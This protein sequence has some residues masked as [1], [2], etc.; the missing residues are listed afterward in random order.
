[1]KPAVNKLGFTNWSY[2]LVYVDNCLAVH[3]DPGPVME[4]LK[5]RYKLKNDKY[6]EPDRYLGANVGKY[7]LAH[8]GGKSYWSMHAYDY[9]V[10]SC[11]MVRIWSNEDERKWNNKRPDA[12]KSNYRPEI[13]F[14]DELGDNLATRFQQMT[15]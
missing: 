13:D 8:N 9:V 4:K 6:G 14:S 3:H 10:E 15:C 5:S 7:Q 2:K 1:M 12:M 11:K